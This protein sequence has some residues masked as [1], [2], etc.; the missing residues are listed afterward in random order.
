[1]DNMK[2]NSLSE[3]IA[4]GKKGDEAPKSG[5]PTS[6]M[7]AH[8]KTIKHDSTTK[9]FVVIKLNLIHLNCSQRIQSQSHWLEYQLKPI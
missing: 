1:M 3:E 6:K 7:D 8:H 5:K 4:E 9:F 2:N